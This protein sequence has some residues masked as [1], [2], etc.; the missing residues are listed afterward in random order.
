MDSVE[1]SFKVFSVIM[2]G[3]VTYLILVSISMI[4]DA[5]RGGK[6]D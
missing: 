3:W 2:I 6:N 4:I 5:I 1:V